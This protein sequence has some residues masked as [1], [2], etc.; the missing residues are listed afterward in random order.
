MKTNLSLRS[1]RSKLTFLS[2]RHCLND[3]CHDRDGDEEPGDIVEDKRR[4]RRVRRL[5]SAP[6]AFLE[7]RGDDAV[8]ALLLV[9]LVVH[10]TLG[11]L[12]LTVAV[13]L[14]AAVADDV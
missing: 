4:R 12:A 5:K 11:V 8:A 3:V 2:A 1:I 9:E 13:V 14:V 6:H 7:Q 10:E